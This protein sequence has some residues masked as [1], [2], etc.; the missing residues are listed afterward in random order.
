MRSQPVSATPTVMETSGI[1]E[2]PRSPGDLNTNLS[3]NQSRKGRKN[4]EPGTE[5]PGKK[6]TLNQVPFRGRHNPLA[7]FASIPMSKNQVFCLNPN[8]RLTPLIQSR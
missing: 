8:Y 3:A 7:G 4:P 5:V 6:S 2:A 1:T